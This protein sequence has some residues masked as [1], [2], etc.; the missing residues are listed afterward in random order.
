MGL[1]HDVVVA[2]PIEI[3][4]ERE[5]RRVEI[6]GGS[7]RRLG[8]SLAVA[9]DVLEPPLTADPVI[10]LSVTVDVAPGGTLVDLVTELGP[11]DPV[12]LRVRPRRPPLRVDGI[13]HVEHLVLA[14]AR[15]VTNDELF[16]SGRPRGEPWPLRR[17]R[18]FRVLVPGV[19]G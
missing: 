2:V 11:L 6:R 13:E 17:T 4:D 1:H 3:A 10:V 14:V 12:L 8:P 7:H 9:V 15:D 18:G 16:G 5:R 19:A